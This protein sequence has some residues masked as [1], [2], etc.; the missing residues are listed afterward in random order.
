[1]DINYYSLLGFIFLT[2]GVLLETSLIP[3]MIKEV[4]RPRDGW[5]RARIYNLSRLVVYVLTFTPFLVLLA[6]RI[7]TPP[8]SR[9]GAWVTVSVPFGLMVL[10]V[11]TH[12]SYTY[13][14]TE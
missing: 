13:K 6:S 10:A 4:R 5:T 1:M 2:I 8:S 3:Q 11:F 14:E 12:L 7:F 9:L